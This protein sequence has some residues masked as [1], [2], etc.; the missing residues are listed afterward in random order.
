MLPK[1]PDILLVI[2]NGA[3]LITVN[4]GSGYYI[5]LLLLMQLTPL[6]HG[7]LS[8]LPAS[9][10]PGH[11]VVRATTVSRGPSHHGNLGF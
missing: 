6:F 7:T 9:R 10:S 5:Q 11:H 4:C 3:L 2:L 1:E 8:F